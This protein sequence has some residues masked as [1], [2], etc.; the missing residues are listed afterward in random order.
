MNGNDPCDL[1]GSVGLVP[2][3]RADNTQRDLTVHVCPACGLVQSLPRID[4]ID[5]HIASPASDATFGNLRYGKQFSI[6]RLESSFKK[7]GIVQPVRC[8]DVGAGKGWVAKA[9]EKTL[10]IEEMCCVEP[11]MNLANSS[12]SWKW[13]SDRIENVQLPTAHFD[14]ITLVH[15]LEHLKS[16]KATLKQIN[17]AMIVG[18]WLYV[19]V[20]NLESVGSGRQISEFFID[21]HLWFFCA[22]TLRRLLKDCGFVIVEQ[23]V[24]GDDL[25]FMCRKPEEDSKAFCD[26][27]T[28]L[29]KYNA[30]RKKLNDIVQNNAMTLNKMLKEGKKIGVWGAG[31][32]LDAYRDASFNVK[33]VT[34][35][36]LYIPKIDLQISR[37][38]KDLLSCDYVII[39]SDVYRTKM[40]EVLHSLKYEGLIEWWDH[41]IPVY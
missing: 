12:K 33:D 23:I 20:P 31:R 5:K 26:V 29:D 21:K 2:I 28:L 32:I 6:P 36:D 40:L 3:Y 34:I 1:C 19:E 15:T 25:A 13:V 17:D 39:M 18:G 16:P 10:V 4:H 9:L 41:K 37:E 27:I 24:D 14:I 7:Q 8:L 11:D 30:G 38:P 35:V 22:A